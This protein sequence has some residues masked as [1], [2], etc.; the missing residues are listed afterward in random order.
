MK[1]FFLFCRAYLFPIVLAAAALT[2]LE[3][4]FGAFTP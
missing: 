1:E 4:L 2:Y 3:Y